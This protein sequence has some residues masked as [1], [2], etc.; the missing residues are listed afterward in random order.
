MS[1]PRQFRDTYDAEPDYIDV[2]DVLP[3]DELEAYFAN[4]GRRW[5]QE[6]RRG[7]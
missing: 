5:V 7:Q 6:P 3:D 2:C 4:H 1:T